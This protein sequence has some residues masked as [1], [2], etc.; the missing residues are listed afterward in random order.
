MIDPFGRKITYLRVSVTDRCDYRCVYCMP[1]HMT[2]VP[3]TE[4]LSLEEL[5][6]LCA[7]FIRKGVER[8]RI[9]GGEPLVRRD[10]MQLFRHLGARLGDGL[11][12][13]HAHHQRQPRNFARFAGQLR[14]AGVRRVN[15]SLDTREPERFR[16]ITRRGDL[17]KVLTGIE[18]ARD[19]GLAV[20]INMVASQKGG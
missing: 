20:K 12:E 14:E 17:E 19:V 10:V 7:A 11:H 13:L 15:V 4:L 2:F 6:R 16:S 8:V 18:A 3:R 5:E 1:E 9:T